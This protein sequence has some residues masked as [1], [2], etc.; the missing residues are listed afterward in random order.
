MFTDKQGE[1]LLGVIRPIDNAPECSSAACHVHQAGQR[2]L[3]VIDADLSLATV[4]AQIAQ[5]PGAR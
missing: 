2:V 3:G 5:Q 4:D 1:H